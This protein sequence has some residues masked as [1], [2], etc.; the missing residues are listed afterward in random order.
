MSSSA[1]CA[2]PA[3]VSSSSRSRGRG[4]E[5]SSEFHQPQLLGGQPAGDS[6]GLLVGH[7]NAF[8]RRHR[9][10]VPLP[11]CSACRHTRLRSHFPKRSCAEMHARPET[12]GQRR[13]GKFRG[14]SG[15]PTLCQRTRC[16]HGRQQKPVDDVEQ[17]GFASAI[18]SDDA[19]DR[20]RLDRQGHVV[21]R[22][23]AAEGARYAVEAQECFA[24]CGRTH[25][26]VAG[27]PT[28]APRCQRAAA[29]ARAR[30]ARR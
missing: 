26:F 13:V 8:K 6:V 14:A 21:D 2:R 9:R 3:S 25:G 23:K 18:W 7:P 27:R 29:P 5:R 22:L 24:S 10:G 12:C 11:R 17:S 15:R 30:R 16:C 19:V 28:Q 4:G 20:S 1:S